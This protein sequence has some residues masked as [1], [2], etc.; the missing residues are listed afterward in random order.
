M[1]QEERA[2]KRSRL[3]R[4]EGRG[5]CDAHT[6][7]EDRYQAQDNAQL[8]YLAFVDKHCH[9]GSVVQ[10]T[11]SSFMQAYLLKSGF[12]IACLPDMCSYPGGCNNHPD[13]E[14]QHEN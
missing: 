1:S 9:G 4:E 2:G 13:E 5:K 10:E 11:G 14:Q 3:T 7:D 12:R 8:V 6:G